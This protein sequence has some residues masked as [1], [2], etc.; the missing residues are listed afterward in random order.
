MRLT[1][2]YGFISFL[3]GCAFLVHGFIFTRIGVEVHQERNVEEDDEAQGKH[4]EDMT[5]SGTLNETWINTYE[6][7]I[8]DVIYTQSI[9][10]THLFVRCTHE[11]GTI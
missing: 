2:P 6:K 11:H 9:R 5:I 8:C 4:L 3:F 1:K 10:S 7:S